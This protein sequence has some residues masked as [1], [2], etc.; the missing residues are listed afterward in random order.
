[1]KA[2]DGNYSSVMSSTGQRDLLKQT[3][4]RNAAR[5]EINDRSQAMIQT[6]IEAVSQ[7][8]GSNQE[9][10]AAAARSVQQMMAAARA[11]SSQP[12]TTMI[13]SST[14]GGGSFG[15]GG[16]SGGGAGSAGS[17]RSTAAKLGSAINAVG[18]IF[19]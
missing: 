3:E 6:A 9:K 1:M 19:S 14:T 8:N 16:G 13:P 15:G 12:A 17:G 18:R 10:I 2:E 4:K 7:A 11:A 5:T